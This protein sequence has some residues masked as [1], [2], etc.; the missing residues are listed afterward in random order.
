MKTIIEGSTIKNA[1][2]TCYENILSGAF[3]GDKVELY[4]KG[5]SVQIE[6]SDLDE[7]RAIFKHFNLRWDYDK[8]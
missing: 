2:I 4:G 6:V 7:A 5:Y 8:K 1:T 3:Y